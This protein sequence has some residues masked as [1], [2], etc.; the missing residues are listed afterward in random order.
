V[1]FLSIIT[2]LAFAKKTLTLYSFL[3]YLTRWVQSLPTTH[4]L[5]IPSFLSYLP[6]QG[7]TSKMRELGLSSLLPFGADGSGGSSG[8]GGGSG[9]SNSA[10]DA[11]GGS[12]QRL[13]QQQSGSDAQRARD[14]DMQLRRRRYY[15]LLRPYVSSSCALCGDLMVASVAE[16]FINADTEKS[17]IDEWRI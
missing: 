15:A 17:E 2:C 7:V 4:S 14:A 3:S 6:Y 1:C 9:S 16:P 10:A 13:N 8:G 12:I 11:A 5:V